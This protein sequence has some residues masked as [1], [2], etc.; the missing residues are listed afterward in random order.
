[1]QVLVVCG[2]LQARSAN[3]AV[4]DV[5]RGQAA[6]VGSVVEEFTSLRD[7]PPFDPDHGDEPG[8]AVTALRAAI[9]AA[10]AVVIAGPEYAGSLSGVVKNA[11]DWIVG[12]GELYG[13]VVGVL[14]AG[15]TG[16]VHAREELVRT[17][18]WQGAHVVESL[19]V[20]A[21]RTKSDAEGRVTDPATL[22]ALAT[23]THSV[24]AAADAGAAERLGQVR[25]VAEAAGVD[26]ARV[27]EAGS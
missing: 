7:V 15:T 14:S 25:R 22:D 18:V 19:G 8:P 26:P 10:D 23:F 2:S 9:G 16:G 17:L 6:T 12:S 1:V 5:V 3:R 11:L 13:R 27:M 24:L 21:P 20:A 4:L